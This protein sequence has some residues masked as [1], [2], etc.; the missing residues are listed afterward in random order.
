MQPLAQHKT[1]KIPLF[2][3]P[4]LLDLCTSLREFLWSM[5]TYELWTIRTV[6]QTNVG[7]WNTIWTYT[8]LHSGSLQ[9]D[10]NLPKA[11][12]LWLNTRLVRWPFVATIF[13][14]ICAQVWV[15]F[16]DQCPHTNCGPHNVRTWNTIWSYLPLFCKGIRAY[17]LCF[18]GP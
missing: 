13:F 5:S 15:N 16:C 8:P 4:F 7:T 11:N 9:C 2:C 12:D 18:N 14:W 6:D 17:K 3:R 1:G 10:L